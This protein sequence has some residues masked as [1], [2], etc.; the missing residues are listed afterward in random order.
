MPIDFNTLKLNTDFTL[1]E[2]DATVS[3][4][5][6]LMPKETREK[7]A[8]SYVVAPLAGGA[9]FVAR[10]VEI[11]EIARRAGV[12]NVRGV[13]LTDLASMAAP[14]DPPPPGGYAKLASYAFADLQRLLRPAEA[15]D[16]QGTT[17]QEARQARDAHPG[18][19]AVV[20]SGGQVVGLLT[21][22]LLSG[23]TL[24]GDPFRRGPAVL[25]ADRGA[26]APAT[27]TTASPTTSAPATAGVDPPTAGADRVFN[28]WLSQLDETGEATPVK[29]TMALRAGLV[30]ELKINLSKPR[31]DAAATSSAENLAEAEG[32][33]AP[34]REIYDVTIILSS[35]DVTLYGAKEQV[36]T[37]WKGS[38]SKNTAAFAFEPTKEGE[39]KITAMFLIDGRCFQMV[40]FSLQVGKAKGPVLSVSQTRGKTV[41][42]AM[43]MSATGSAPLSDS[44]PVNLVIMP[45]GPSY[46]FI[47]S[48]AGVTRA[49]IKVPIESIAQQIAQLRAE[50]KKIVDREHNGEFVYQS[51]VLKI[52]D[53]VHQETLKALARQGFMLYDRLFYKSGEDAKAMG[54]LLKMIS[55]QRALH[56]EIIAESFIFPWALLFD[57]DPRAAK[58]D[59][60]GFWGFKHIIEYMPEFTTATPINF[61]PEIMSG[62]KLPMSFICNTTIDT[63][64]TNAG[65][66]TVIDPQAKHFA[67]LTTVEMTKL[68]TRQEFYDLLRSAEVP[69]FLYLN[70]HAVSRIPGEGSAFES[71]I[72]LSDGEITINDLDFELPV[73]EVTMA[74][75]P[76]IFI[77]ACQ[78]AELSPYLYE[79]LVPAMI[80]RGARGV[81][82]TEVDT[83]AI[84]AADFAKQFVERFSKGGIT[85]GQL[86]LDLRKEYLA[87]NNNVMAL[88]YALY[89]SGEVIVSRR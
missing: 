9:Y 86:L 29:T 75:G 35:S 52:P 1:V 30:Y 68:T 4:A 71:K 56:I 11:E 40:E 37:I 76:L 50:L 79:G 6:G 28:Y 48:G 5:Y 89:S 13:L 73:S 19:R 64:L 58:I 17:T 27:P 46:R 25:S 22:E 23:D 15:L 85:L 7:L 31:A 2:A 74:S 14:T 67:A 38:Y 87:Q 45:D 44:S 59:P 77:N 78:S 53:A 70:C 10:W 72:L 20:L 61:V 39:A 62:P 8:F 34:E 47:L 32:D 26:D 60:Q 16:Q 69:P 18:K 83:P 49:M 33:L 65:Y 51:D 55:N 24:S 41:G 54:N 63:E 84:F 82:G 81:I 57:G 66:P 80:Q 42:S 3:A 21:L 43:K 12:G 88:L 36:L